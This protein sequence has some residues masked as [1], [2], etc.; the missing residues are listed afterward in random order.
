VVVEDPVAK[1]LAAAGLKLSEEELKKIKDILSKIKAN[2]SD[3]ETRSQA[4][5]DIKKTPLLNVKP[6]D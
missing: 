5:L 2:P 3:T 4:L 6:A 1:K